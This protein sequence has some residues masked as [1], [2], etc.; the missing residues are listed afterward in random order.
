MD[1]AKLLVIVDTLIEL[2]NPSSFRGPRLDH[3]RSDRCSKD[4][5]SLTEASLFNALKRC[6]FDSEEA[7]VYR[8]NDTGGPVRYNALYS[9]WNAVGPHDG[10]DWVWTEDQWLGLLGRNIFT[11]HRRVC[12]L[13]RE[14]NG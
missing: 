2:P 12:W 5:L 11:K 6:L 7:S 1:R 14:N 8:D 10:L 3:D 9:Q 4:C 13:R